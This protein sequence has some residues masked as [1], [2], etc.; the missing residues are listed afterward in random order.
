MRPL[1]V[2]IAEGICYL[3]DHSNLGPGG[4]AEEILIAYGGLALLHSPRCE[5][6]A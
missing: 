5:M 4:E 1:K 6:A 3:C 2:T